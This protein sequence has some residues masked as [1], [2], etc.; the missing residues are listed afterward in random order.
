MY[1][2][3]PWSWERFEGTKMGWVEGRVVDYLCTLNPS[4][5]VLVWWSHREPAPGVSLSSRCK[6]VTG[7]KDPVTRGQGEKQE[8][9]LR[10]MKKVPFYCQTKKIFLILPPQGL[11][12]RGKTAQKKYYFFFN[13][14]H[15]FWLKNKHPTTTTKQ[16]IVVQSFWGL[17]MTTFLVP[18][19]HNMK[20]EFLLHKKMEYS[21]K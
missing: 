18:K 1:I 12:A 17:F 21:L 13:A 11:R 20:C 9:L 16:C 15:S 5:W 2:F 19:F 6:T 14:G 7:T 10:R 4:Q 8:I 3:C